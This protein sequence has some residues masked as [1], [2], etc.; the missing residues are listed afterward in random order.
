MKRNA[1]ITLLVMVL[2]VG[3]INWRGAAQQRVGPT[4]WEYAQFE[5]VFAINAFMFSPPG[6]QLSSGSLSGLYTAMTGQR[7]VK[8]VA[9]Q[10]GDCTYEDIMNAAGA[11]GWELV[12]AE[13]TQEGKKMVFKRPG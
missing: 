6:P 12:S 7:P 11:Q 8:H 13:D 4:R 10:A 9:D 2:V 5:A 1:T 3:L